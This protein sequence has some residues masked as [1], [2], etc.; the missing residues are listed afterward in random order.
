MY[1]IK[2]LSLCIT[3]CNI[4]VGKFLFLKPV[5]K[6]PRRLERVINLD[7]TYI[8]QSKHISF[9]NGAVK[10]VSVPMALKYT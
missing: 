3:G 9:G 10:L 8:N 2:I 5:P 1:D 4:S 7:C 6:F